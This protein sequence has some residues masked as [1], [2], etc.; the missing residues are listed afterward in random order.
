MNNGT[1]PNRCW[2][3]QI[4]S[5]GVLVSEGV[6]SCRTANR[7]LVHGGQDVMLH[8]TDAVMAVSQT[9]PFGAQGSTPPSSHVGLCWWRLSNYRVLC[10]EYGSQ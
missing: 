5:Q 6:T 2:T 3:L 7:A 10:D 1:S 8:G 4:A 9:I